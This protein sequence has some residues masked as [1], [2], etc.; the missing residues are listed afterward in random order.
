M[1]VDWPFTMLGRQ[2]FDG[3]LPRLIRALERIADA[4][5]K[6]NK[7]KHGHAPDGSRKDVSEDLGR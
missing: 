1:A 3:H 4:L 6:Q 5:E 2:F 7:E